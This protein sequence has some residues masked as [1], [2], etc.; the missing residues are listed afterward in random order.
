MKKE[1][2][3]ERMGKTFVLYAGLLDEAHAQGLKSIK[4]SLLQIPSEENHRVAICQAVVETDKGT[5]MG[6]GDAS[7]NNV[8]PA[9]LN[10]I[11]RM[12]E[13]RAKARALRDAVNVGVAALEELGGDDEVASGSDRHFISSESQVQYSGSQTSRAPAS[14]PGS[15]GNPTPGLATPAQVRAIYLI[16]RDQRGMTN[17][18]VEQQSMAQFGSAPSSLTKKQASDFITSL[19]ASDGR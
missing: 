4:T 19:R 9:M 5:Y 1:F 12:A 2:M 18:D 6:I 13:T 16:A 8:T 17:A 7:P 15:N 10:C 3:V 14:Q 11:I